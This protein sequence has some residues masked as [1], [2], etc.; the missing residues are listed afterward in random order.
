M[1]R[2]AGNL[3]LPFLATGHYEGRAE[4][5]GREAEAYAAQSEPAGRFTAVGTGHVRSVRTIGQ[6]DGASSCL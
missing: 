5:L 2:S 6:T 1:D 4:R 3:H